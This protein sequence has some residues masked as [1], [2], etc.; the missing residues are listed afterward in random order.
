[1]VKNV[2]LRKLN[3]NPETQYHVKNV[4]LMKLNRNPETNYHEKKVPLK[5]TL[6]KPRNTIP[7]EEGTPNEA[8][9]K[10]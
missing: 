5:K 9:H 7:C 1:M 4:P 10:P 6:Q 2:P 3:R 8:Q